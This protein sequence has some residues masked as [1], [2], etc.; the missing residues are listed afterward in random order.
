[1]SG[2]GNAPV[3]MATRFV[4]TVW[5]TPGDI[6]CLTTTEGEGAYLYDMTSGSVYDFDLADQSALAAR[7]LQPRWKSFFDFLGWYLT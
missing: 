3:G 1:M 6:I 4:R 2:R 5:E 7:T